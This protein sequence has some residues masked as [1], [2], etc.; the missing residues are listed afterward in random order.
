MDN[1]PQVKAFYK[2]LEFKKDILDSRNVIFD[3]GYT[4]GFESAK[5]FLSLK[6]KY[7]SYLYAHPFAGKTS[8]IFDIYM[9]IAKKYKA[10][11]FIYS[12]ESGNKNALA[13][14]L[15]QVY[16]G[17]KLHGKN[18]KEATDE[19]WLEAL[20]FIDKHFII[21][22]PKMVG[23][24]KIEFDAK[25][26]FNQVHTA[27]KH[28]GIKANILLV[29][30]YNMLQKNAEERKKSLADYT[31][32][33][34]TYINQVAEEMDIHIQIAMHLRGEEQSII[35]KDTGVEYLPKPQPYKIANG[36]SVWRVAKTMVGMWRC[37]SG[38]IEKS[39]GLL[40]PENATDFFVQKQKVFGAGEVGSFR[41]FFD[42][43]RQKFYEIINGKK[44]YCGEYELRNNQPQSKPLPIS[45]L[46]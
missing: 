14:Y 23:K 29:D 39:S 28:Y 43:E 27:E 45:N 40:Y 20:T 19:E 37:P 30:P 41:L 7:T 18:R 26:M 44:Y 34:L 33:N 10:N 3:R 15:V 16:L 5:D 17:K 25:E 46:F 9:H 38:V 35:D 32:E 36:Q 42:D 4:L 22:Q 1:K 12:P 8:F 6:T 24:D 31:L 13:A 2:V 21:L 11:I